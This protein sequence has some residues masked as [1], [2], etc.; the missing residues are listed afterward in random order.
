M[1]A[2]KYQIDTQNA[3]YMLLKLFKLIIIL[4]NMKSC[5]CRREP[6]GGGGQQR[7]GLGNVFTEHNGQSAHC[8]SR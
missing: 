8:C 6:G 1:Y 2:L 7:G 3:E 4:V 5:L